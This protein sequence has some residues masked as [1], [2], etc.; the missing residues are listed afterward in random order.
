METEK[1][2]VYM[3]KQRAKLVRGTVPHNDARVQQQP[4]V[5]VCKAA[6]G[7]PETPRGSAADPP[8][9][10]G[11]AFIASYILK[12]YIHLFAIVLGR[13]RH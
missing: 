7:G 8:L 10:Q 13:Y 12:K 3:T 6:C 4:P 5:V 11:R 9:L 2:P 1:L